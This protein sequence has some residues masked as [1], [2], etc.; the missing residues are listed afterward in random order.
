V[1]V[2]KV[3]SDQSDIDSSKRSAPSKP[4]TESGPAPLPPADATAEEVA[5][6]SPAATTPE[7]AAGRTAAAAP[8]Q[9]QAPSAGAKLRIA[10]GSGRRWM[11]HRFKWYFA[12]RGLQ[13]GQLVNASK[14][15]QRTSRLYYH[16][17]RRDA[18]ESVA[19]LLPIRVKL[20]ELLKS[21]SAMDL[22]VGTDL[23]HFDIELVARRTKPAKLAQ[24]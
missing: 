13:V 4:V 10:N 23:N 22:V 24:R 6:R 16:S 18:A 5:S 7:E 8:L 14:Y 17:G 21:S 1:R 2:E 3:N 9:A 12:T 19:E 11:A 20:V 15:G